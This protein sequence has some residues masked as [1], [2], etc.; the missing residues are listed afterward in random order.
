[1]ILEIAD[2]RQLA[3]VQSCVAETVDPLV[4]FDL[5]GHEVAARTTNDYF[6]AENFHPECS[7]I[8]RPEFTLWTEFPV[9]GR[10]SSE[11]PRIYSM[12]RIKYDD[13]QII[14]RPAT[15]RRNGDHED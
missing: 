14:M 3:S 8:L 2:D 10:K 7:L 6:S 9:G 13:P 12:M 4:G 5:Q 1:M 15:A 11:K